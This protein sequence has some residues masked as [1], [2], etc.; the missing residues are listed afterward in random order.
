MKLLAEVVVGF[1]LL[2]SKEP[3]HDSIHGWCV[4][5]CIAVL[6]LG[7]STFQYVNAYGFDCKLWVRVELYL[8]A[9]MLGSTICKIMVIYGDPYRYAFARW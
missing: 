4:L 8:E 9:H 6:Q 3:L 2:T 7:C 5:D 1:L